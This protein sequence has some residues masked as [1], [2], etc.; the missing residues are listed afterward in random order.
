MKPFSPNS[1]QP[2]VED[3]GTA[4]L[5]AGAAA[6]RLDPTFAASR[7]AGSGY[8]IFVTPN[9]DTRG[10]RRHEDRRRF[11]RARVAGPRSTVTFDDRIVPRRVVMP[12]NK[13]AVRSPACV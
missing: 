11:H 3:I 12:C 1:T 8:R 7:D 5:V 4:R 9:S 13:A 6:V 10:L 2:T